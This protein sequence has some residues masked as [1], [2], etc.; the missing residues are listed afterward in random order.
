MWSHLSSTAIIAFVSFS[1]EL[2]F[3]SFFRKLVLK[4]IDGS[5]PDSKALG[6]SS[7][8][9]YRTGSLHISAPLQAVGSDSAALLVCRRMPSDAAA[10]SGDS[11]QQNVVAGSEDMLSERRVQ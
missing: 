11:L 1:V 6:S 9:V 4:R 10:F 3:S 7:G 2:L 8:S 5:L